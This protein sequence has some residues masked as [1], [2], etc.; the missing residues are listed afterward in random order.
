MLA[1]HEVEDI[2]VAYAEDTI[3]RVIQDFMGQNSE[4]KKKFKNRNNPKYELKRNFAI[5]VSLL[6]NDIQSF[7][8]LYR[9][10]RDQNPEYFE[11]EEQSSSSGGKSEQN[12]DELYVPVVPQLSEAFY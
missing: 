7:A 5:S 2:F 9:G 10:F 11:F 3:E 8:N 4:L 6:M 1:I 12:K